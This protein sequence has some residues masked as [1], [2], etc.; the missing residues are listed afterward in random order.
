M[1]NYYFNKYLK[2]K[3]KYLNLYSRQIQ[4]DIK[5]YGGGGD[6]KNKENK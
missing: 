3:N 4:G 1:D 2:Y 5:M 6:N